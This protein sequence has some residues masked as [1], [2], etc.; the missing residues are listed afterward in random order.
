MIINMDS[1]LKAI[2]YCTMKGKWGD[3]NGELSSQITCKIEDNNLYLLSANRANSVA[4]AYKLSP[5]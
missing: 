5:S 4:V 3:K 2:K 1:F